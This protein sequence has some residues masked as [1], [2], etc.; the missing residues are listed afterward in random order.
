[1]TKSEIRKDYLLNKYVIITPGRAKRPRDIKEQTVISRS[2]ICPFCPDK[3]SRKNIVDEIKINDQESIISLKNIFPAVS[4]DNPK[5]YGLQEVIIETTDHTK[6]LDDLPTEQIEQLLQMYAKRTRA[7]SQNKK[8]DYILCFKN[9]GSKAGASITHAHSQIFAS[10]ILP[11]D[12][13]EELEA[14]RSYKNQKQTCAYCDIINKEI[15][16]ER[17]IF[18]NQFVAVFAPYA[19]QYHYEAW[20][21][22]KRHLDNIT[23]LNDGEFKAF[24]K[25]LKEILAKIA[26]LNLSYNFFL[27]QIVSFWDQHFY[28]KIQPRESVWAGVELG[29]GL[30][31]NS[32]SPEVAAKYYR[33]S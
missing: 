33:K 6:E 32:I 27:H 31:I 13:K 29:S 30:V 5:A 21:F 17:K 22:S 14:A 12:I 4:L 24:A 3:L 10:K 15:K 28:L 25:I 8:I 26:L 2:T 18:E 1:M 9:Q 7:I 20:I 16:T 11:P 23:K 19:S